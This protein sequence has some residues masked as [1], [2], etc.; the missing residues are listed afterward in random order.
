MLSERCYFLIGDPAA[1]SSI[2]GFLPAFK[3]V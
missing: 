2:D 3:M 1:S